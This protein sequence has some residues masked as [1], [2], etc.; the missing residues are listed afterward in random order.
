MEDSLFDTDS[1]TNAQITENFAH[2]T[3]LYFPS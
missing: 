1:D 3:R 2:Q